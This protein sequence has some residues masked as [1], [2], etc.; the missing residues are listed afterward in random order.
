[1]RTFGFWWVRRMPQTA[2]R[3][4]YGQADPSVTEVHE[5]PFSLPAP[6]LKLERVRSEA[7]ATVLEL[8]ATGSEARCPTCGH[9]ACRIQSRYWR[10]LADL[11]CQGAPVHLHVLVRRFRC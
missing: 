10:T 7:G 6:D 8:R 4:G 9:A 11:P 2:E 3:I 5:T 1:M